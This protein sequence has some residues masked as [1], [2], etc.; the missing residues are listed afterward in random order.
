M[1]Q[2]TL[3]LVGC[4]LGLGLYYVANCK[5][6]RLGAPLLILIRLV[7]VLEVNCISPAP[8]LFIS[9]SAIPCT[10]FTFHA[11]IIYIGLVIVVRAFGKI[12]VHRN[13]AQE[14]ALDIIPLCSMIWDT[15]WDLR[16]T[17]HSHTSPW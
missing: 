2:L 14:V 12:S 1:G 16:S 3:I 8:S 9:S 10:N 11:I 7:L 6:T 13:H 4:S 5:K 15:F 17:G